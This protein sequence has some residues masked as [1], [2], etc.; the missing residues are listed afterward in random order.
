MF[1]SAEKGRHS[2][3]QDCEGDVKHLIWQVIAIG[4]SGLMSVYVIDIDHQSLR[5]RL[6]AL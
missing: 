5:T 3:T 1:K 4:G 6:F 2:H